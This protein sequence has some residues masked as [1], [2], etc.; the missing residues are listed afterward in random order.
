[1]RKSDLVYGEYYNEEIHQ[2]MSIIMKNNYLLSEALL[3]FLLVN[4]EARKQPH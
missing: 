2:T 3:H 1:M 4:G